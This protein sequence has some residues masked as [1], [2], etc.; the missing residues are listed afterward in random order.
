LERAVVAKV[1]GAWERPGGSLER[2]RRE[3][4]ISARD[5]RALR[6]LLD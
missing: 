1:R 5:A 2:L 3:L 4:R 6:D